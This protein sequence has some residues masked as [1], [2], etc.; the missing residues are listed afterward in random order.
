MEHYPVIA[1]IICLVG[2]IAHRLTE[3]I[4]ISE[5]NKCKHEWE[6]RDVRKIESTSYATG[7]K[8]LSHWIFFLKCKKCGEIKK[9]RIGAE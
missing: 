1:L 8:S 3:I 4:K 2:F 9:K 7:G 6:E 5:E